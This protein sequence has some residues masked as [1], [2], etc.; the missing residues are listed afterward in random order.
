MIDSTGNKKSDNDIITE[1]IIGIEDNI[2]IS[3][4]F[5]CSENLSLLSIDILLEKFI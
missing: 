2:I 4:I 1:I 3:I 5:S